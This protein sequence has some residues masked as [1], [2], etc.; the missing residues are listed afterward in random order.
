MGV[1]APLGQFDAKL[2]VEGVAATSHYS[3]QKTR[4][5]VLSCGIRM[6]AQISFILS[7][8]T[9]LTEDGRRDGRTD[10][11]T[12]GSWLYSALHYVQSH[13]NEMKKTETLY[14]EYV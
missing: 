8:S 2:Q 7:Q 11:S 14:E 5:H 1:F 12:S 3:R 9:R 13:G 6:W 10:G 4:I